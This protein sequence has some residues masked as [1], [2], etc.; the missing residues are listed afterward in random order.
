MDFKKAI[1]TKDP[2]FESI[3][4]VM[5]AGRGDSQEIESAKQFL[6]VI[7]QVINYYT[8][9]EDQE[10][11]IPILYFPICNSNSQ[12]L[13]EE[14]VSLKMG[15]FSNSE[16][17]SEICSVLERNNH[18]RIY[19]HMSNEQIELARKEFDFERNH[20]LNILHNFHLQ[21]NNIGKSLIFSDNLKDRYEQYRIARNRNNRR[22]AGW[23]W[24]LSRAINGDYRRDLGSPLSLINEDNCENFYN[25][26]VDRED[27]DLK[28]LFIFPCRGADGNYSNFI[29]AIQKGYLNDYVNVG[30]GI[31]NVFVF[32]FS[33]KPFRLRRQFDNKDYFQKQIS[34]NSIDFI[35]FN[36]DEAALLF[37]KKESEIK[38]LI[39]KSETEAEKLFEPI[40]DNIIASLDK[41][42][43]IRCNEA[44][45]CITQDSIDYFTNKLSSESETD[46]TILSQILTLNKGLWEKK[47]DTYLS[48]FL[49]GNDVCIILANGIDTFIK[50]QVSDWIKKQYCVD[51]VHFATFGDLRG[52]LDTDI[53]KN[54]IESKRI[55]ILS[56][57]NDYTESIFHKYPNSFDPI[58]VNHDQKILIIEN[59]FIM[60]QYYDIGWNNYC[61]AT[62]K[63]LKSVFRVNNMRPQFIRTRESNR[64]IIED[65]YDE[66]YDRNSRAIQQIKVTFSDDTKR[67]FPHNEWMIYKS[68]N[69]KLSVLPL[70][71]LADIYAS[72]LEKLSLQ[73]M[74]MLVNLIYDTFIETE[75]DR[76]IQS[77]RFFKENPAYGLSPAEIENELQLWKIL[78]KKKFEEL[79]PEVVYEQIMTADL[80]V[81]YSVFLKWPNKD[82]GLPKFNRLQERLIRD[83]LKIKDPYLTLV[84]RIKERNRDNRE[85]INTHI[86]LFL[87]QGLVSNNY[88]GIFQSTNEET[89][90]ILG[91]D[92]PSDIA[93]I[94]TLINNNIKLEPIKTIKV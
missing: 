10:L 29:E 84:R 44:S 69:S 25:T 73:P 42:Y 8:N 67:L 11:K 35:T 53:Y 32:R 74:A 27:C 93:R 54:R 51:N 46:E 5:K 37:N 36:Y 7:N 45:L 2:V 57:R 48:H 30:N 91:L 34:D 62:N 50:E 85:S 20:L 86:K 94:I 66:F 40:F 19:T 28:N 39:V 21:S 55:L 16:H 33:R 71:D 83:Y 89:R 6:M 80:K 24:Y 59:H 82:Y 60:G 87:S 92:S 18:L 72:S 31:R 43:I 52:Y 81:G 70:S 3:L 90:E 38:K 49:D 64:E 13:C 12:E 9:R 88:S 63:V 77:E 47:T 61:K 68:N 23:F 17:T 56:F 41:D 4:E 1:H 58:C 26:I 76:D 65:T 15:L 22:S 14:F 79:S 78:L 75:R